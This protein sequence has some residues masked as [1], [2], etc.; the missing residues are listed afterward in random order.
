MLEKKKKAKEEAAQAASEGDQVADVDAAD[1]SANHDGDMAESTPGE[2][3]YQWLPLPCW[4]KCNMAGEPC[5]PLVVYGLASSP[6][7]EALQLASDI[8]AIGAQVG[9]YL[10]TQSGLKKPRR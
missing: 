4:V 5:E 9:S 8:E 1:A 10:T 6:E 3:D 2:Q 7:V